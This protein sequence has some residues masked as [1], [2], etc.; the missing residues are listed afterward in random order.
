MR[1]QII[2]ISFKMVFRYRPLPWFSRWWVSIFCTYCLWTCVSFNEFRLSAA[3]MS[4][5][6][7]NMSTFNSPLLA[8]RRNT[9]GISRLCRILISVPRRLG[10]SPSY[11][12]ASL[13][14]LGEWINSRHQLFTHHLGVGRKHAKIVDKPTG[15][16][17]TQI[18][19]LDIEAAKKE[20]E[21]FN[22]SDDEV[23]GENSEEPGDAPEEA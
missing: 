10:L 23:P 1:A 8:T 21:G 13:R 17:V 15:S 7:A 11:A 6:P 5:K 22:D 19:D 12:K 2:R 3:L 16:R 4:G 14:K 9:M 18:D 20:W